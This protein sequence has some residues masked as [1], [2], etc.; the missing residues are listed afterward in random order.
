[1]TKMLSKNLSEDEF[2][3]KCC[4][5]CVV[6]PVY[7]RKFQL[8]RNLVAEPLVHTNGYRCP[9]HNAEVGGAPGSF[10]MKGMAGDIACDGADKARRYK[11]V[12]YAIEVGFGGIEISPWHIHLDV[13][14][15]S[16][17]VVLIMDENKKIL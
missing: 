1:M 11:I 3:C 9:K 2:K 16:Q 10:H 14:P 8:L 13:R 4:G 6:D 12:K 17:G 7:I 15:P 5:I